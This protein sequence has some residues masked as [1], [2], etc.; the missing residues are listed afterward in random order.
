MSDHPSYRIFA[1]G[2]SAI[3]VDWGNCIN[4]AVNRTVLAHYHDLCERPLPFVQEVI[5]A[6]SSLTIYYDVLQVRSKKGSALTAFDHM[7]QLLEERLREP[8]SVH[9]KEG[10]LVRIPVCYE[11][12]F[13]TD[14]VSLALSKHLS[15]EELIAIHTASV[16]RVYMLGFLPGFTY[17]GEVDERIAMPRKPVPET[18]MPGSVGIA[19]RQTGVYPL[20]S[21]G[22][23]HIIGRTPLALFAPD[24]ESPA[25]LRAGDRVQFYSISRHEFENY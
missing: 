12:P 14:L 4:E 8:V 13:A 23:W 15:T 5:S 20:V 3:T 25:L 9:E 24:R 22:G 19:G 10:E 18:V 2:D 6:Y 1:L 21:P 16:Y 17:M 7:R 11:K